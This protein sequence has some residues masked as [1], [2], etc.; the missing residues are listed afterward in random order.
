[1][2]TGQRDGRVCDVHQLDKLAAVVGA[3]VVHQFLDYD[4]PDER[5]RICGA[6]RGVFH[7]NEILATGRFDEAPERAADFAGVEIF[8]GAK[9]ERRA[10]RRCL[11]DDFVSRFA[12]REGCAEML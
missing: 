3:W 1:M 7:G 2:P 9:A 8:A 11:D 10:A 6:E 12:E 5:G 4:R